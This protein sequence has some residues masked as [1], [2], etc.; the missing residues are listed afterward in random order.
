MKRKDYKSF[1]CDIILIEAEIFSVHHKIYITGFNPM[2]PIL[3]TFKMSTLAI[4]CVCEFTFFVSNWFILIAAIYILKHK[5]SDLR[6]FTIG[7]KTKRKKNRRR[8]S[9]MRIEWWEK[10]NEIERQANEID[11]QEYYFVY[12][13]PK[14]EKWKISLNRLSG[15]H[16]WL[17]LYPKIMVTI[18]I[19]PTNGDDDDEKAIFLSN[20]WSCF[21]NR[22]VETNTIFC[23]FLSI[24]CM[25]SVSLSLSQPFSNHDLNLFSFVDFTYS[26]PRWLSIAKNWS[27][28]Q[29]I[30]FNWL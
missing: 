1:Y 20:A 15:F 29:E 22:T 24:V 23:C 18:E 16:L 9:G 4:V 17:L 7:I 28:R 19:S 25:R 12:W 3:F 11:I 21:I 14:L 5:I 13:S 8:R 10:W 2:I 26:I 6:I 30:I 27:H